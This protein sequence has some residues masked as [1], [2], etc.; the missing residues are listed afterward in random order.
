MAFG[1]TF[2]NPNPS[3]LD[4][5]Q[6]EIPTD[7]SSA[8]R[9]ANFARG[10]QQFGSGVGSLVADLR[11]NSRRAFLLRQMLIRQTKDET[12]RT[13]LIQ[14]NIDDQVKNLNGLADD[15]KSAAALS[16]NPE[17]MIDPEKFLASDKGEAIFGNAIRASLRN[18]GKNAERINR[19]DIPQNAL[20]TF[21][22]QLG[23]PLGAAGAQQGAEDVA[24]ARTIAR[25]VTPGREQQ[26]TESLLGLPGQEIIAR[27]VRLANGNVAD[28]RFNQN[29]QPVDA[30]GNPTTL[31]NAIISSGP[32]TQ[33]T[34]DLTQE[35]ENAR[36]RQESAARTQGKAQEE[37][38]QET[39]QLGFTIARGRD[40]LAQAKDIGPGAAGLRAIVGSGV[41]GVL[42]Q[43]N[44]GLGEATTEFIA[45]TNQ[46]DLQNFITEGRAFVGG[47]ISEFSGEES[48]RHTEQER[49][50]AE[51]AAKVVNNPSAS[52]TQLKAAIESTI[53]LSILGRERELFES[54]AAFSHDLSTSQGR[55]QAAQD[56]ADK[57]LSAS[58]GADALRALKLL[59]E[60]LGGG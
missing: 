51:Q 55:L 25:Q 59:Q 32:S 26:T 9:F 35:E 48:G 31:E 6:A 45:G 49:A 17:F 8:E 40:L 10:F 52:F 33:L 41:G 19:L 27:D 29:F 1:E 53:K 36:I 57:G 3:F 39:T 46:T 23:V 21:R 12:T 37:A 11:G 43:L 60:E 20:T 18:I 15:I 47:L 4:R 44:K 42:G 56:M 16:G 58:G 5:A 54:G 22:A 38:R 34:R 50:I 2:Q 24:R 30:E 13:G 14:Q 7:V 28:V